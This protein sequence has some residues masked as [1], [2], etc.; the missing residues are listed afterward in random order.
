MTN[1]RQIQLRYD[2]V[3][4][5][6]RVQI[7]VGSGGTA[8]LWLTRRLV[9]ELL[10]AMAKSLA[11]G[12]KTAGRTL[13]EWRDEVLSFEHQRAVN[14]VVSSGRAKLGAEATEPEPT[15]RAEIARTVGL[16][17]H[18]D[19]SGRLAFN[20]ESDSV[21]IDL[22][23]DRL[24]MVCALLMKLVTQAGGALPIGVPWLQEQAGLHSGR[25]PKH[26]DA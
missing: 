14:E 2:P 10:P 23:A 9:G 16:R 13:P 17:C 24:H 8:D 18:P 15:T 3:E 19:G 26:S 22:D 4:D 1:F 5:R 11:K 25:D 20:T 12:S 21:A 6:I 7:A